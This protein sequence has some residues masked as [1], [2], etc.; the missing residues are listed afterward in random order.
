MTEFSS[1]ILKDNQDFRSFSN[2]LTETFD[3]IQGKRVGGDT[4]SRVF[5]TINEYCDHLISVASHI[6]E[7][8]N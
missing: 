3:G 2:Y 1:K 8:N 7:S 6:K 4:D 5:N